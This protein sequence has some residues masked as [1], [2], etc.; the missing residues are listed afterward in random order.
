VNVEPADPEVIKACYQALADAGI[1]RADPA[2]RWI[3]DRGWYDRI[4]AAMPTEQEFAR[5]R[6]HA[7]LMVPADA[8]GELKCPAC[9]DG[10]FDGMRGLTEHVIAQ[11][12]PMNREPSGR[13]RLFGLCI[14]VRD[15]GGR[16]HLE[17]NRAPW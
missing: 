7:D 13:D 15:D 12:D 17:T 10:P 3:M 14:D 4:R 16:P 6:A 1:R 2:A 5:A 8:A 9:G 11:A